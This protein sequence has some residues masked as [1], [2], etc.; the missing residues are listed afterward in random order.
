MRPL[1]EAAVSGG[2]DYLIVNGVPVAKVLASAASG[3]A[4]ILLAALNRG[5]SSGSAGFSG[6]SLRPGG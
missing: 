6:F 2:A 1:S 4:Y 3:T 5:I